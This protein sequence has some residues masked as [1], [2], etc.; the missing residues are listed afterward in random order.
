M[1]GLSEKKHPTPKESPYR[2]I[3]RSLKR[4]I[5][6]KKAPLACH[7]TPTQKNTHPKTKKNAALCSAA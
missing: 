7:K 2:A 4:N 1:D 5:P 6:P 3:K